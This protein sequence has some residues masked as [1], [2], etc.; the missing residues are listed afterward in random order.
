MTHPINQDHNL[1]EEEKE[2]VQATNY[3]PSDINYFR[4]STASQAGFNSLESA[5]QDAF[6]TALSAS[7]KVHNVIKRIKNDTTSLF[8]ITASVSADEYSTGSITINVGDYDEKSFFITG[9]NLSQSIEF[10]FSSSLGTDTD[11]LKFILSG[12][13]TLTS[14]KS[15]SAKIN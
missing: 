3:L 10:R 12:S 6:Y 2:Y 1:R 14:A 13:S 9:S 7:Y 15:A 8:W 5:N 11:S 4:F